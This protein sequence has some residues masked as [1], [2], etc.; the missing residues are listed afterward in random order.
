MKSSMIVNRVND[1][2]N[3]LPES[4]DRPA[5]KFVRD[6][7]SGL[8]IAKSTILTNICRGLSGSNAEF[9]S[10]YKRLDRR[11]NEVDLEAAALQQ[12]ARAIAEIQTDTII[13]ID[14]GDIAKPAA[15]VMEGLALIADG[16][17][18]HKIKPGYWLISAVGVNPWTEEK[19][20]QPLMLDMWSAESEEFVSENA[21]MKE[22]ISEIHGLSDGQGIHAI[23]R[24][25][26]WQANLHANSI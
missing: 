22:V 21:V 11:I 24:G 20:P 1:F 13:A 8:M 3:C 2:V 9:R 14:V 25:G 10:T 26:P 7:V 23:D 18:D 5:Q 16:S 17:D 19:T 12:R 6:L 4:Y 15:K